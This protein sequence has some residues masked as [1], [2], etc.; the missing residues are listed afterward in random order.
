VR[1]ENGRRLEEPDEI[2]RVEARVREAVLALDAQL[3]APADDR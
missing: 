2:A 1:R 3:G